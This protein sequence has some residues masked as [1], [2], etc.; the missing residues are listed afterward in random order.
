MK[1]TLND[2]RQAL[3]KHPRASGAELCR[4]LKGVNRSTVM[5]LVAQIEG[6]VIRR[7]GSRRTRYV[8]RRALRGRNDSLPLYRIDV[9]GTGHVVGALDLTYPEGSA[10]TFSEPFAWPLDKGEMN[11]GWFDGLPYPLFDMRPQG[12]LG[13]NFAHLYWQ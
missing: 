9:S 8:L 3:M 13:R 4:L 1:V 2:L 7:S 12:F 6:E 10:L 5:R 11:D